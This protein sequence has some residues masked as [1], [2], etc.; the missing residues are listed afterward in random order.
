MSGKLE[1]K[2]ER[3][4]D[5]GTPDMGRPPDASPEASM[6]ADVEDDAGPDATMDGGGD[7]DLGP[8]D[9]G[10]PDACI[11]SMPDPLDGVDNDCNGEIDEDGVEAASATTEMVAGR[12]TIAQYMTGWLVAYEKP[13]GGIDAVRVE[14]STVEAGPV[15]LVPAAAAGS[16][17][18]ADFDDLPLLGWTQ[19][20]VGSWAVFVWS[21]VSVGLA[22]EEMYP[23]TNVENVATATDSTRFV[24]A[25]AG[26]SG[27]MNALGAGGTLTEDRGT[28]TSVPAAVT[29]L[30]TTV[31]GERVA[32][33]ATLAG[34]PGAV[35][36]HR[37]FDAATYATVNLDLGG[38]TAARE[39]GYVVSRGAGHLV[40]TADVSGRADVHVVDV[41][42]DGTGDTRA[43]ALVSGTGTD[44][45][46]QPS[47]T[48]LPGG[49]QIVA[50]RR[51]TAMGS[52]VELVV[53][54]ADGAI[55]SG[56]HRVSP[57]G[58][59]D[60]G[61]PAVLASRAG[62]GD[63]CQGLVAFVEGS[64]TLSLASFACR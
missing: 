24:I 39:P 43:S 13:A 10:D 21:D 47:V 58:A 14:G 6:E 15:A 48:L 46:D 3:P 50:Y 34:A 49:A 9:A 44:A 25:S 20:G 8:E 22:D 19:A 29:G 41:N 36:V 7:E 57:A 30:A 32:A 2:P 33:V 35:L 52:H 4:R 63:P 51:T 28:T 59:R 45:L 16:P 26:M 23:L 54:D 53:R 40:L 11:D 27:A 64:G 62:G 1:E 31:S 55:A 12:P 61:F 37:R 42:P 5:A 17:S 18:L 60:D 56:P 38:A